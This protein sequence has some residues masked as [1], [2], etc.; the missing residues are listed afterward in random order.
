MGV[1][2]AKQVMNTTP[3][4]PTFTNVICSGQE[5]GRFR[6]N[7]CASL[8]GHLQSEYARQSSLYCALCEASTVKIVS[9]LR[10]PDKPPASSFV[11]TRNTN[12]TTTRILL[13]TLRQI[14]SS[15]RCINVPLPTS[16]QAEIHKTQADDCNPQHIFSFT[17][18]VA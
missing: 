3:T 6:L 17:R 1:A 2:R 10:G 7:S 8:S 11:S 15:F 5:M 12:T 14:A 9:C 13:P 4:F 18:T 16:L